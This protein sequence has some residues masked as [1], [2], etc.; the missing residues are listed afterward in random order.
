M[1]SVKRQLRISGLVTVV[2]S[3]FIIPS[4]CQAGTSVRKT[5]FEGNRLY[6][7]NRFD[8]ALQK[9]QEADLAVP[10]SA[11]VDFNLGA[12]LY[13]KKDYAKAIEHFT[14][15]LN[16]EDKNLEADALY[17]I[18]NCKY[19]QAKLKEDTDP[20]SAVNLM[21][22]SLDYYKRSAEIKA[23]D[24]DPRFN[25]EFVQ[26]QL[27]ALLEK[28]KEAKEKNK[29]GQCPV[30]EQQQK[31]TGGS[32]SPETKNE[33]KGQAGTESP[34]DKERED[35]KGKSAQ[36][37]EKEKEREQSGEHKESYPEQ[38]KEGELSKEAARELLEQYGQEEAIPDYRL[39]QPQVDEGRVGKDW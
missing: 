22:E 3:L 13:K 38:L 29:A 8:E 5:I 23:K 34:K 16:S 35:K 17:N 26:N 30:S 32:E 4:Y 10:D 2:F 36:Q 18:G 37:E 14:K 15:A 20:S 24:K 39:R 25:Y 33:E 11:L 21:R 12:A 28:S 19:R 6:R 7:D 9:Y 31:G 1:N 27:K